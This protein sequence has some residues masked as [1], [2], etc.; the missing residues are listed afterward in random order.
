MFD[1]KGVINVSK[2]KCEEDK[3][4]DVALEAGADDI[5]TEEEEYFTV[6]TS[7]ADYETIKKAIEDAGIEVE[8]SEITRIPQNTIAVSDEETADQILKLYDKLEDDDD[9]QAVYANFEIDEEILEK[10][11]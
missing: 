10:L 9:V 1:K 11:M 2:A 4:M 6:I 8:S 3:I 5:D 7:F